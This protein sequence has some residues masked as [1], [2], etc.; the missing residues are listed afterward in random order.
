MVVWVYDA[1]GKRYAC[2]EQGSNEIIV[3][4]EY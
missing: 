4:P 1:S 3:E 2:P